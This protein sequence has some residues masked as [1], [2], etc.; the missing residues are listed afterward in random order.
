LLYSPISAPNHFVKH[1]CRLR[2]NQI[3]AIEHIKNYSGQV[4]SVV[5]SFMFQNTSSHSNTKQPVYLT[6]AHVHSRVVYAAENFKMP[7]CNALLPRV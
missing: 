6:A 3:Y 1:T 2:A 4:S 7:L 5:S